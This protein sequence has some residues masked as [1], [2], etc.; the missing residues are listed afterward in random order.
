MWQEKG[1]ASMMQPFRRGKYLARLADTAEDVR[2]AQ[3]LRWLC[4]VAP[5]QEKNDSDHLD[6]DPLDDKCHHMLVT[7]VSTDRLVCC[8]RFLPLAGGAE[9]SRSYSAQ[10]YNLDALRDFDGPMAEIGRFCIHP[11][12]YDPDILRVAWAAM[13][14]F[15]DETGVEMLFGC[16]SFTGTEPEE[17]AETFA[18]LKERHLAPRRW[19][20]KVKAPSA[21]RFA[22]TPRKP[23]LK[24]AMATMPPLLRTYLAMGAWVSDHAVVDPVLRTMHV[25]T[26]VEIRAIPPKRKHL[27]RMIF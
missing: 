15:V 25:F 5:T 1:V 9:I 7:D 12:L 22:R 14:R 4:F 3:H 20:P 13:T 16:T 26:G 19:L 23:D 10:F 2:K 11:A 8:F 6:K 21:F 18:L 27:L 17:H 24:K